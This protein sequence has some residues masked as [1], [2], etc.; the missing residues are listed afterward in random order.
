MIARFYPRS[1]TGSDHYAFRCL[2]FL[3]KFLSTL[4]HGERRCK[5][6]TCLGL[7]GMRFLRELAVTS[8][9]AERFGISVFEKIL[10]L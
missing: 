4:P 10:I 8:A 6:S 5:F 9:A 1:R 7:G 2:L 3:H